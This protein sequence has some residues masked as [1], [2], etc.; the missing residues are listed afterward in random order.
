MG[1]DSFTP[2]E[3]EQIYAMAENMTGNCQQGSYRRDIIISNILRR[4]QVK[5]A[6]NLQAY[7][8]SAIANDEEFAQL[9]SA[10]TIH[11]TEWFRELPHYKK[12]EAFLAEKFKGIKKFRMQSGG[13]STGEEVYSFSIVLESF[14]TM[15]PGFDYEFQAFDIDPVSVNLAK[16]AIYPMKDFNKIPA[17]YQ[18]LVKKMVN[19][20]SFAPEANIKAK[21]RFFT[22]NL[23]KLQ[24]LPPSFE[25]IVCRNVLIYFTP[26]KVKEIIAKL[27]ERLVKGGVLIIGHSDSVDAKAFNLKP[28]GNSMFEKL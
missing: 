11:T 17:N 28:L 18:A 4:V 3:R 25:A 10:F 15:H 12:F 7:L 8:Q 2:E 23:I 24:S 21:T 1:V 5:K 20:D 6:E 26:D 19:E 14:R 22:D 9:L 16:K 27:V 13:C